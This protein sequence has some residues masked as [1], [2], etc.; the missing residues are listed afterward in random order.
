LSPRPSPSPGG[1]LRRLARTLAG[2]RRAPSRDWWERLYTGS[3]D[4]FTYETSDYER[5]KYE[6]TLAAL[7][8]RRF[9]RALEVGCSIGV[10]PELLAPSCDE[11]LAVDVSEVALARARER[12][13]GVAGVRL[14]QRSLPEQMPPG[15][16]DLIV[17]SEVL[18][19][20]R[21]EQLLRALAGFES[22]L[23][24]GG[25][26]LIVHWRPRIRVAPLR[27]DEVHDLVSARTGLRRALSV[28]EPE[29]RLDRFD[30]VAVRP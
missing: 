29:Y 7:E 17:A 4:P 28:V 3:R 21:R 30:R 11:L 2:A 8:G 12:L 10:F 22:A 27:G 15:P 14:E 13:S 26:L 19:F 16:F 9:A 20:L 6:R 24:D 1:R 18:M 23:A 5:R 25:S